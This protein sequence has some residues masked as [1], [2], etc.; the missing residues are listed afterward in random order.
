M[1][2]QV[3]DGDRNGGGE[4][5]YSAA[6]LVYQNREGLNKSKVMCIIIIPEASLASKVTNLKRDNCRY[7]FENRLLVNFLKSPFSSLIE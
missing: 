2:K 4:N 3:S 6:S 5:K 7:S 1:Q